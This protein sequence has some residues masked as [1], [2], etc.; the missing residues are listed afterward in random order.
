M[1]M[2]LMIRKLKLYLSVAA[3][4]VCLIQTS[5]PTSAAGADSSRYTGLINAYQNRSLDAVVKDAARYERLGKTDQALVLYMIAASHS[6][7]TLS[8]NDKQLMAKA[9]MKMGDIYYSRNDYANSLEAY[10]E[11]LNVCE[12]SSHRMNIALFLNNIGKL[13]CIF[14]DYEKGEEYFTKGYR[15]CNRHNDIITERKLTINLTGLNLKLG[16]INRARAFQQKA[17]QLKQHNDFA[18]S[19]MTDFN[20]ALIKAAEGH[21]KEA[22]SR[23][24]L[25]AEAAAGSQEKAHYRCSAYQEIYKIYLDGGKCDS[26]RKYIDRCWT[27]ARRWKI[28][29]KFVEVLNDYSLLYRA[30]GDVAK[31]QQYKSQ[32]LMMSDTI[33]NMR[34]I[35]T[36]R[37]TLSRYEMRKA[38]KEIAQLQ[39]E[40]KVRGETIRSQR[41]M[42]SVAGGAALMILVFLIVVWRQNRKLQRSYSNLYN[43]NRK[44][45][46]EQENMRRQHNDDLV[47]IANLEKK[48][49]KSAGN[50]KYS[51]SNLNESNLN[52]IAECIVAVM[53]DTKEL[54]S[55]DFSLDRLA[56]LVGSNSKYV[57]QVINDR[58]NKN[59]SSYVN[60]RRIRLACQRLID[61]TYAKYTIMAIS[62][63]V[64]YGTHAAFINA[65]RKSTGLTPSQ[66]QKMA[67][68]EKKPS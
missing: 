24:A 3:C 12:S 16:R 45:I 31:S 58:F 68:L 56:E 40:R 33:F 18:T 26:A 20:G 64:G 13:Y 61:P 65:F 54:C 22:V 2:M 1:N 17:V 37:N 53:D 29:H 21:T 7:A 6:S 52:T 44:T 14:N 67:R 66:Y 27:E 23:F 25:L 9:F 49:E 46:D 43:I 4:T 10:V 32:Y 34:R 15:V 41:I 35:D 51:T 57:S 62:Q 55:P 19:F 59:F 63:S 48:I 38:D 36:A 39:Y 8:E 50:S 47:I 60:D 42:L 11:G 30:M 5:L 28:E